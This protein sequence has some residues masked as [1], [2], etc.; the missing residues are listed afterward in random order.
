MLVEAG[1]SHNERHGESP[2]ANGSTPAPAPPVVPSSEVPEGL[3]K[4]LRQLDADETPRSEHYFR[5]PVSALAREAHERGHEIPVE[6]V[7]EEIAFSLHAHDRQDESSWGLYFGPFASFS[8]AEGE[9]IDSPSLTLVTP[10]V[11]AHW[12][13]RALETTNPVMRAR[14]ADLLWELPMRLPDARPD[15]EMARLAIDSYVDAVQSNRYEY[16]VSSVDKLKRSLHLALSLDD[17]VRVARVRD[18]LIALEAEIGDDE[19]PGLWGFSFDALVEPPNDRI[20]LADDVRRAVIA[21]LEERLQRLSE[22]PAD[23]YHPFAA[24]GAAIRLA[25]YYRRHGRVNDVARVLRIHGENV[26]KMR[27]T[28]PGLLVAHSLEQLYSQ[29]VAYGL[30]GDAAALDEPIRIAGEQSLREMKHVSTTIEI[31]VEEAEHYFTQMLAGSGHEILTRVAAHFVPKRDELEAQLRNFAETAPLSYMLSRSI[32]DD[33]GR[34]VAHVGPIE[35]DLEGQLV[36]H[37][38]QNMSLSG[39]WLREAV[40]RGLEGG[41][42]SGDILMSFVRECPLFPEK[43]RPLLEAG[44]A[45]YT[46]GDSVA[47]VHILV[48][49]IEQAVRQLGAF[50]GAPILA[51][52]RNGGFQARTLDELLRDGAVSAS[53][54]E[55]VVTYLRS[56]LTD[57]RGWNLRNTVCH[58][59]APASA[60]AMP[61]ADRVVHAILVLSLVRHDPDAEEGHPAN[62][63]DMNTGS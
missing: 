44:F 27:G 12:R 47:A 40:A 38:A 53:L 7:A 42:L 19:T 11:L 49:Q 2:S 34:T 33:D 20:D 9:R 56:L 57:A 4:L 24:E 62:V 45:A 58:G 30:R 48:P 41:K 63:R 29:F 1:S 50:I 32:V 46:T 31:P 35:N 37:I 36:A 43:R 61:V 22:R 52:R 13:R 16:E 25:N 6:L 60:F 39:P 59:L 55:S 5:Q 28:A 17:V 26:M 23:Q 15:A 14:Y 8:N 54:G 18:A 51:Q 21:G 3:I 10:A